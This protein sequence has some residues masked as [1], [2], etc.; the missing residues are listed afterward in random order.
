MIHVVSGCVVLTGII[1][2][3]VAKDKLR[4]PRGN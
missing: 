1:L 3:F 2:S 4:T